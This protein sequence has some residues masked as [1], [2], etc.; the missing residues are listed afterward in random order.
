VPSATAEAFGQMSASVFL[1]ETSRCEK[2][3]QNMGKSMSGIAAAMP[4]LQ[5]KPQSAP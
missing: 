3:M 4:K 1:A 5:E 2:E